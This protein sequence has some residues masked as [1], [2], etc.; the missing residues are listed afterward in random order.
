MGERE[1][2]EGDCKRMGDKM[3]MDNVKNTRTII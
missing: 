2:W 3:S 1:M